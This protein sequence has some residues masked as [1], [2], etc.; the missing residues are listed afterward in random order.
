MG[1]QENEYSCTKCNKPLLST[2]ASYCQNCG[3][4]IGNQNPSFLDNSSIGRNNWWIWVVFTIIFIVVWQVIGSLPLV[5]LCGILNVV[6]V[7]TYTCDF[8]TLVIAGNSKAPNFLMMHITFV[9]GAVQ[10]IKKQH[11][12]PCTIL[13][14]T[15]S[16]FSSCTLSIS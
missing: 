10:S 12:P 16:S 3:E 15:Y 7:G 1:I 11:G 5:G 2:L 9:V 13:S 6:K 14:L 8:E 4:Y